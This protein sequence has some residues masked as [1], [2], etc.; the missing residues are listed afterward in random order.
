MMLPS[1]SD[2]AIS[3]ARAWAKRKAEENRISGQGVLFKTGDS[4]DD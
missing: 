2:A 1:R 4:I 3:M